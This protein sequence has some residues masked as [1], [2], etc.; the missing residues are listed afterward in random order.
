LERNYHINSSNEEHDDALN[1]IDFG[2][3]FYVIRKNILWILLIII[4]T[5]LSAYLYI[6]YTKPLFESVSELKLDVKS[7]ATLLGLPS[8]S[9]NYNNLSGEIQLIKSRHFF[10]MVIKV[11][12]LEISY[13]AYGSILNEERYKNS[14]FKVD[15]FLKNE[16]FFDKPIDVEILDKSS[17]KITF[18][19][20]KESLSEIR[21]FGKKIENQFFELTIYLN[22]EF[23][24]SLKN[25]KFYF[26]INS[27]RALVDFVERNIV[28]EPLNLNA[29]TIKVGFKDF[30][31]YKARDIV[32]AVARLYLEYSKEEKNKANKQK[33]DFLNQQ[34]FNTEKRLEEF[35]HYFEN[36]TI[37]NKTLNLQSEINDVIKVMIG[38][39]SQRFEIT[40]KIVKY[41]Q[42]RNQL[43]EES[44]TY[45][46]P[47]EEK[48]YSPD[49]LKKVEQLNTFLS[50]KEL[51]LASYNE[52]TFAVTKKKQ[53]IDI[54]KNSTIEIIDK[55]ISQLNDAQRKLERRKAEVEK[56][57]VGL[58][59]KGTEYSKAK[60]FH[61]LFEG[62]YMSLMQKKNEFEIAEAGT[63]TNFIVLSPA[64]LPGNP[65][66]PKNLLIYGIGLISGLIF[67]F[68]F[69]G[70][71]YLLHNKV[72]N[73]EE[74][75]HLT[76]L[77]LL[78]LIP[79]YKAEK[80]ST[81]KL[82]VNKSP[83]SSV[84]ESIRSVRTNLDFLHNDKSKKVITVTSTVSGEGKTF[85][86]VNLAG[87]IGMSQTKVILLD[88]DMR[89]PKVQLAF[90]K[91]VNG[92]GV[93]TLLIK[94][95]SLA[96]CIKKTTIENLDYIASGPTPP[97]P[98]ELILS[99]EFDLVLEQ[100]KEIYDVIILDT[101]PVGLVT[102]GLIAMKKSDIQIYVTRADYTKKDIFKTINR[103]VR[104]NNFNNLGL[105]LNG[106]K[107][108]GI[109]GYGSSYYEDLAEE[110]NLFKRIFKQ[111]LK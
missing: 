62:F 98:S 61:S 49:L 1:N 16:N 46:N 89:R 38:L 48:V 70:I 51:L 65:I 97:N 73:Q 91:Y 3:L 2:K 47:G 20:G 25:S 8:H 23:E 100:L 69:I 21:E 9:E 102:D 88:L 15:Y 4:L 52:N 5:N 90:E 43:K 41:S 54:L 40:N 85:V 26:T 30:N 37:D 108:T 79:L 72:T 33:I 42:F 55:V 63:V 12:D 11:L 84:S 101:P 14:P 6:R 53:Q 93:S 59:S 64:T 31:K 106:V 36:F 92:T 32:D 71:G 67:S 74:L 50:E 17:Y 87:I 104:T 83:R 13:F 110:K 34:L 82:I 75:E 66:Y 57:F 96:E 111:I 80:L 44:I 78:G 35:E 19:T 109:E 76:Q 39:D 45:L 105:I 56:N 28:V 7:E 29:N 107:R 60:R 95:H 77:P 10:N 27:N 99:S 68:L 58:P 24:P 18:S 22:N 103:F 81:T 94:K 86:A